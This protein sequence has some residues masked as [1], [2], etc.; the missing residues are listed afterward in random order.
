LPRPFRHLR[1]AQFRRSRARLK[2][3]LPRTRC[4]RWPD[5]RRILWPGQNTMAVSVRVRQWSGPRS[6]RG[7][8]H[9][10]ATSARWLP[11]R[12]TWSAGPNSMGA[13]T[14]R[15]VSS[16]AA[17]SGLCSSLP[18]RPLQALQT[19]LVGQNQRGRTRFAPLVILSSAGFLIE[20]QV[21]ICAR[22][23][24][25]VALLR[26]RGTKPSPC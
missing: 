24:R 26:R 16:G 5:H 12:R 13:G 23:R 7:P 22:R 2:R 3:R 20:P 1:S 18:G 6:A 14:T 8:V 10:P 25:S 19:T 15:R 17:R 9:Q 4:A 11:A 21:V